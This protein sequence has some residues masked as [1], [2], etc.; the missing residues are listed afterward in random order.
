MLKK[1]SVAMAI[2]LF[3]FTSV[4]VGNMPQISSQQMLEAYL[5]TTMVFLATGSQMKNLNEEQ[6]SQVLPQMKQMRAAISDLKGELVKPDVS[7]FPQHVQM[8]QEAIGQIVK[9]PSQQEI[10]AKFADIPA[11]FKAQINIQEMVDVGMKTA[12]FFAQYLPADYKT[13]DMKTLIAKIDE[14]CARLYAELARQ[15]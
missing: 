11:E 9:V 5:Q 2:G 3:A 13:I 7:F 10:E 15:E 12:Q 4:A 1:F 6:R 14:G 8:F